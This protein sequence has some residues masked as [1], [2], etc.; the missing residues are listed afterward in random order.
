[1]IFGYANV[2]V[3]AGSGKKSWVMR[4]EAGRVDGLLVVPMHLNRFRLHLGKLQ[5][6]N[7][8]FFILFL[9]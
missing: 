7:P 8:G 9:Y 6:Y 1:M 4:V 5:E 2:V 3:A